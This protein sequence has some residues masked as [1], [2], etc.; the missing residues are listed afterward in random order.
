[1]KMEDVAA[2]QLIPEGETCNVHTASCLAEAQVIEDALKAEGIPVMVQTFQSRVLDGIL[3]PAHGWGQVLVLTTDRDRAETIIT[4]LL[5]G[6]EQ[7]AEQ[8]D[9]ADDSH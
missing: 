3:I 5:E 7:Q 6:L 1:M 9:E 2:D 4:E 8:A